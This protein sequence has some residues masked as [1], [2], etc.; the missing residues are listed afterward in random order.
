M[1]AKVI[2]VI[3]GAT[4]TVSKKIRKHRSDIPG[5]HEIRDLQKQPYWTLCT[6]FGKY[7]TYITCEITLH[8]AQTVNTGQLQQNIP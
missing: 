6:L 2:S 4:G 5:K 7:K 1:Q 3:L 8:V